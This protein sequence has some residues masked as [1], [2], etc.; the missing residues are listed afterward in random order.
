MDLI[1]WEG[2]YVS[3]IRCLRNIGCL[4][5][6]VRC[7]TLGKCG[8]SATATNQNPSHGFTSVGGVLLFS[9]IGLLVDIR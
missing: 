6:R 1:L 7:A 4:E 2:F 8:T 9:L 3:N 5:I